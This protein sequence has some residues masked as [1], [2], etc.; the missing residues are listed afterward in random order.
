MKDS[1]QVAF[2]ESIKR[3]A[4]EQ[5]KEKALEFGKTAELLYTIDSDYC[6]GAVV[7]V[8]DTMK[9]EGC[10]SVIVNGRSEETI[11]TKYLKPL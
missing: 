4:E 5:E 1:M 7:L 10:V 11:N 8:C 2:K 3:E 9:A 6:E